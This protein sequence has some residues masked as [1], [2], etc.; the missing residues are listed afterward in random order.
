MQAFTD[1]FSKK[2]GEMAEGALM[3]D[4]TASVAELARTM[5]ARGVTCALVTFGG[6]G[7]AVGIVTERDV[8]YRVLAEGRSPY[9]ITVEDIMSRPLI[10][11]DEDTPMGEAVALMRRKNI[12]RVGVRRQGQVTSLLNLRSIM[13]TREVESTT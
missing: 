13:G 11:V 4:A 6:Q 2:A 9:K 12:L 5:K 7:N 1:I 3:V 8:I 10:E